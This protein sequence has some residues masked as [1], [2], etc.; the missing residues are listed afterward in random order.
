MLFFAD[1]F[2]YGREASLTAIVSSSEKIFPKLPPP[3]SFFFVDVAGFLG[4]SYS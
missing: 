1:T 3:A 4:V 2:E